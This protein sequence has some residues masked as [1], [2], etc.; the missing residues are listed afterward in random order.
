MEEKDMSNLKGTKTEA[1]LKEAF[2]GESMANNKYSYYASKA[3]KDG[4]EQIA[5]ILEETAKNER[6][7]AKL[8]FKLLHDGIGST[9]ANLL[10]AAQGEHYEWTDMYANFAK[11]AREQLLSC[12][13]VLLLLKK[14]TKHVIENYWKMWKQALYFQG[15]AKCYGN[16]ITV[17]IYTLVQKRQMFVRFAR[18][19]W[20]ILK[21][22][23]KIIKYILYSLQK[24]ME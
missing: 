17:D 16:V 9:S 8:W 3:K 18:T 11:D 1:N 10:D 5:S 2:A 13:K 21:S 23:Q 24:K 22:R 20:H 19:Q 7:H 12:L 4:F 6:E 14:N 15:M